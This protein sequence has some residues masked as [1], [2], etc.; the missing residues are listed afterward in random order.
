MRD[1]GTQN[2]INPR[3]QHFSDE[4][5]VDISRTEIINFVISLLH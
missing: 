2:I 4:G 3:N 1:N 5:I